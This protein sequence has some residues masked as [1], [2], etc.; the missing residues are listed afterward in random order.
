MV[1]IWRYVIDYLIIQFFA[2]LRTS[3]RSVYYTCIAV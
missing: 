2:V 1:I 3:E